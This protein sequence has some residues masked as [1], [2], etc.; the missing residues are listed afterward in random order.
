MK[1][2]IFYY[3]LGC[4]ISCSWITTWFNTLIGLHFCQILRLVKKDDELFTWDDWQLWLEE[5]SA[6]FGE[7]LSCPLCFG[8]WVSI[9][10]SSVITYI[11]ELNYYFILSAAFSWPL[12]IFISYKF[13]SQDE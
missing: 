12:F 2:L 4:L 6:F 10:V 7:L 8:F 13:L 1:E 5:K 11:N 3:I 9:F